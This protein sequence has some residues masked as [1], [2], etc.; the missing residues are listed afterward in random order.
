M[1]DY[2][3][4]I[5]VSDLLNNPWESD[6]VK[7]KEKY[8]DNVEEPWISWE[9]FLQWLNHYEV[10]IELK[11]LEFSNKFICDKCL[12][13]YVENLNIKEE[14]NIK[15][16][17][18]EEIILEENIHDNTFPMD[19]KNKSINIKNLIEILVK[20]KEPIIKDC[21]KHKNKEET[22]NKKN[23]EEF[24]SYTIDFWKLLK[25]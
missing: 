22:Y 23:Q 6:I 17:N 24:S 2:S 18:T 9:I 21:W 13:E 15:F 1:K 12:K 20:N 4:N 19:S 11:N 16:V 14:K 8:I 25:S 10:L 3:W 5:K 7:F